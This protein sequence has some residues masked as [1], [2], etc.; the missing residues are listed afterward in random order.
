M[1]CAKALRTPFG[2]K[3]H[4][5]KEGIV[6]TLTV[7]RIPHSPVPA[8]HGADQRITFRAETCGVFVCFCFENGWLVV[9]WVHSPGVG[10]KK[11]FKKRDGRRVG[12]FLGVFKGNTLSGPPGW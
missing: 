5:P 3:G 1:R 4:L 6:S 12:M 7:R 9:A 8:Q 10:R 11:Y 2:A